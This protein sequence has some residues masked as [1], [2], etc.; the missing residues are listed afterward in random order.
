MLFTLLF[1]CFSQVEAL[2]QSI[3]SE[4]EEEDEVGELVTGKISQDF[5]DVYTKIREKDPSLY[6]KVRCVI[7]SLIF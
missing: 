1:S 3:E 6:S 5:L 2:E 7:V 4:D